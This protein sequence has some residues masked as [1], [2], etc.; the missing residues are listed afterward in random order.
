MTDPEL[1]ALIAQMRAEMPADAYAR[2]QPFLLLGA[3]LFD[4][5][6]PLQA[7][8]MFGEILADVENLP[9][10]ERRDQAL[11]VAWY[12]IACVAGR[13]GNV[14]EEIGIYD[15]LLER[16]GNAQ[17][18]Y[19]RYILAMALVN[20]AVQ[21][22]QSGKLQEAARAHAE[23]VTRFLDAPEP[24]IRAQVASALLYGGA[25]HDL[26]GHP[27]DELRHY[28]RLIALCGNDPDP[29]VRRHV[30]MALYGKAAAA[31]R[32]GRHDEA[33]LVS[34]ELMKRFGDDADPE[35]RKAIAQAEENQRRFADVMMATEAH[36]ATLAELVERGNVAEL[37]AFADAILVDCSDP[38]HAVLGELV[39]KAMLAPAVALARLGRLDEASRALG[40]V[41]ERV[42]GRRAPAMETL[43]ANFLWDLAG[44]L[45]DQKRF[46][47]CI[48]LCD[49]LLARS[50]DVANADIDVAVAAVLCYKAESLA[51]LGQKEAAVE[52]SADALR[53]FSAAREPRLRVLVAQA[54]FYRGFLLSELDRT[55][56]A[57]AAF[58]EVSSR[59]GDD[60]QT[61]LLRR[62]IFNA[63]VHKRAVL[64]LQRRLPEVVAVSEELIERFRDA[65]EPDIRLDVARVAFEMISI[66]REL[67]EHRKA[68]AACDTYARFADVAHPGARQ[69]VA[70]ARV[71]KS[72][73]LRE[74]GRMH[75][76]VQACDEVI[77][78]SAY[79]ADPALRPI[80]AIALRNKGN[81]LEELAWP[82]A[83]A[84]AYAE[85][86]ARFA[87]DDQPQILE[88]V[89][90]AR[91]RLAVLRTRE[92]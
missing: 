53:R 92:R 2:V 55:D 33:L 62:L 6:H 30:A 89:T 16:F 13:D 27:E 24:E 51:G 90:L 57:I 41:I 11:S 84:D 38:T 52:T 21:L 79:D 36:Q 23:V 15:R 56:E 17:N 72:A 91:E 20:R 80:V 25:T 60:P 26:L 40:A 73:I 85:L 67:G 87:L 34:D 59:F 88:Q 54:L 46:R 44:R 9:H 58:T 66:L 31:G 65:A 4:G 3:E 82:E 75:E 7:R 43:L 71:N 14:D 48:E 81:L 49:R 77:T 76:A 19:V 5:G 47:E 28:D 22:G 8:R 63:L 10:S 1:D 32:L 12:N 29:V 45:M 74:L 50:P 39:S 42:A 78:D 70:R 61:E 69:S 68:I 37:S 86:A 64:G 83:A 35:I 18:P